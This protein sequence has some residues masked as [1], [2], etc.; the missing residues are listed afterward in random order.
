MALLIHLPWK[1]AL[2]ICFIYKERQNTCQVLTLGMCSYWRYRGSYIT[3]KVSGSSRNGP[4]VARF[5]LYS[6]RAPRGR[7]GTGKV[8][9]CACSIAG[10][11]TAELI[12]FFTA[13]GLSLGLASW[14]RLSLSYRKGGCAFSN[15]GRCKGAGILHHEGRCQTEFYEMRISQ[16]F[17]LFEMVWMVEADVSWQFV[18]TWTKQY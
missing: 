5:K 9:A 18:Y 4:Q 17:R 14:R 7:G 1:A 8:C 12:F 11:G 6:P 13:T 10:L 2:L 3:Q 16:R 15:Y